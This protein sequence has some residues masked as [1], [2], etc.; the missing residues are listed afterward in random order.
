MNTLGIFCAIEV[1]V[2]FVTLSIVRASV[3]PG[4]RTKQRSDEPQPAIRLHR[5]GD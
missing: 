3:S 5:H 2:V 4:R 1:V